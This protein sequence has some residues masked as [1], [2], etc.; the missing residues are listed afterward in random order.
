MVIIF[1]ISIISTNNLRDI[2]FIEI[3][4]TKIENKEFK[5]KLK[6]KKTTFKILKLLI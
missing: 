1:F 3:N 5:C 4:P 2:K 6:F